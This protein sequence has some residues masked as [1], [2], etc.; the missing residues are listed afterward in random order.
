M[1][2]LKVEVREK[3]TEIG[4]L[5]KVSEANEFAAAEALAR[6]EEERA[7]REKAKAAH[8]SV[9]Q[10]L[11][12]A[13][14]EVGNV[15]GLAMIPIDLMIVGGASLERARTLHQASVNALSSSRVN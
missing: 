7:G 4:D 6:A 8:E 3:S 2:R 15:L 12:G 14:R 13:K 10:A 1:K 9:E 5:K 11:A